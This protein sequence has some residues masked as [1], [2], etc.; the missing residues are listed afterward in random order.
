MY[1]PKVAGPLGLLIPKV[2]KWGPLLSE[3]Y[4]IKCV[5]QQK[6]IV[7]VSD[8][9]LAVNNQHKHL[10]LYLLAHLGLL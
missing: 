4:G 9:L 6:A 10:L 2:I 8:W 7:L 5:L 3:F 1:Y